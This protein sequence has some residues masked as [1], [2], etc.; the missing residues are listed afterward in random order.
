MLRFQPW[1]DS[2]VLLLGAGRARADCKKGP[3]MKRYL[4]TTAVARL[5][6]VAVGSVANWI[7][8]GQLRA[9]R[10]PGGHRRVPIPE[11]IAFLRRQKL[12]IPAELR[13]AAPKVLFVDDEA[14]VV[15]LLAREVKEAH[16]E[17]EPLKAH[18]GFA[19]GEIVGA[20]RPEIVVLDIYMEG[21][22]GL[23]VCR[24]IKAREET[25]HTV[26]IAITGHHSPEVQ[27]Q[28]L[29]AGAVAC[30][31]KPVDMPALLP[32]IEDAIG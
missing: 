2:E 15:D 18:D 12:P 8:R 25:R 30:L 7:D 24:R 26:V 22:D 14:E 6:G 3:A 28:A 5:L 31:P 10:T 9:G 4:S 11:L 16:P 19:A 13:A 27:E 32:L 29:E 21:L 23:E 1:E 20:E 17:C